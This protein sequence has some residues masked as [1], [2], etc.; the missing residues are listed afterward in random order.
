LEDGPHEL[1]I[2]NTGGAP[3][4]RFFDFDYAVVNSTINPDDRGK[5]ATVNGASNADR[6]P[7][8]A[9]DN[10]DSDSDGSSNVGAI[11]GGVAGG[12]IALLLL[13]LLAWFLSKKHRKHG[14]ASYHAAGH[15]DLTGEEVKPYVQNT[16]RGH[17]P[18]LDL[19]PEM[20][21]VNVSRHTPTVVSRDGNTAAGPNVNPFLSAVPPPPVS[22]TTSYPHSINPPSSVGMSPTTEDS[23]HYDP[24][25]LFYAPPAPSSGTNSDDNRS[26]AYG[27]PASTFGGHSVPASSPPADRERHFLPSPLPSKGMRLTLPFTAQPPSASTDLSSPRS[28]SVQSPGASAGHGRIQREGR[29]V[30]IGPL[31]VPLPASVEADDEGIDEVT[32]ATLP[33]DYQQATEPLPGQR[34]RDGGRV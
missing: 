16:A 21:Y 27:L 30:D 34:S 17:D 25:T 1:L 9:A 32:T 14:S 6:P 24:S 8:S 3:N 5:N 11:A 10:V 7:N 20:S 29:E 22:T 23:G 31:H 15:V 2:T 13:G 33:P 18:N 4:G 12:V 28:E 26:Q 19:T